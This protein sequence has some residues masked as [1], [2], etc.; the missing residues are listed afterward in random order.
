[1][2]E[3]RFT[4]KALIWT[5]VATVIFTVALVVFVAWLRLGSG[6]L[7]LLRAVDLVEQRFVGEYD[8]TELYDGALSGLADSLGDRWSYYLTAEEY[9]ALLQRRSNSYVGVGLTYTFLEDYSGF[10][11]LEITPSGPAE[12]AGLKPGEIVRCVNGTALTPK[13]FQELVDSI[14][15]EADM[16]VAFTVEDTAGECREVE[17][18][19]AAI[20]Q[21]PVEYKMLGDSIGYV[22]LQ[23]FYQNSSNALQAAV[24]DLQSQGAKALLFD[25][26]SNPGGY[27]T[28]LTQ[29]LDFLLPEGPIF[30]Q[31]T[32]TG[33]VEVI[34]SD[35]NCVELPM[36]VL[37]NQ[38]SY[39]A[40]ELFAAQLRES[41]SAPLIGSRTCGKGYYQQAITLPG[42]GALN[43]STG[44]YTTGSGLSLIGSGLTPDVEEED[45][46]AQLSKALDQ[47]RELL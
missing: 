23:N 12:R 30:T 39:S 44:I 46:E 40:A 16:V 36:A 20:E 41:V 27:V 7:A 37:I 22:R 29:M 9:A 26:R 45:P 21:T 13:N 42:G 28:E 8:Q 25:V 43:L 2:K 5:M 19:R 24:E 31:R 3:K 11:I 38:D 18:T 14:S 34:Q 35:A 47:L 15:G 10:E 17:I 1:M 32:K 4:L 6:G 33:P